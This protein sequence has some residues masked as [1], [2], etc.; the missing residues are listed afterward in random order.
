LWIFEARSSAAASMQI[1][2]ITQM[3]TAGGAKANSRHGSGIG[4]T[5]ANPTTISVRPTYQRSATRRGRLEPLCP[6]A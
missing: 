6:A 1:S 2:P 5:T 4:E 3:S